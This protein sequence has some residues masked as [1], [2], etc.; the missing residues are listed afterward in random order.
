MN[1]KRFIRR[2]SAI[3]CSFILL[4]S[5]ANVDTVTVSAATTNSAKFSYS[6]AYKSSKYYKQLKKVVLTGDQRKD[7]VKVALSQVGYHEGNSKSGYSGTKSGSRNYTEYGRAVANMHAGWCG[8]FVS[9]CANQANIPT[10]IIKKTGIPS[11]GSYGLT[12]KK[13]SSYKPIAGDLIFFTYRHVGIVYKVDSKYVYT[14]EGNCSN[15]VKTR[16][17]SLKS[18][19]I[20]GYGVP[21]YTSKYKITYQL[22]GGKN[23]AKNVSQYLTTASLYAP[24]R[25]GYIFGGWYTNKSCTGTKVVKLTKKTTT[26]YAK[27]IPISYTISFDAN[28]GSGETKSIVS[29]YN[30]AVS[31]AECGFT[32]EGYRLIGWSKTAD[33]KEPAYTFKNLTTKNGANIT[34][35]AV[36]EKDSVAH[37]SGDE[38]VFEEAEGETDL[39]L[40]LEQI[41]LETGLES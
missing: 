12:L 6:S 37:I 39:G 20:K 26:V 36:W 7:I 2:V 24:T 28:G 21:K 23:N 8:F 25:T 10:T 27:W 34:L 4:I 33:G 5:L 11:A 13:K 32:R 31:I 40:E 29:S 17:Y 15:K 9:W 3:L 41:S 1:T 35:Y 38:A 19:E 16:K 22:N 18:R 14:V 30:K